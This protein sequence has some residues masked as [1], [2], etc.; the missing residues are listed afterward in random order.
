MSY[1]KL[2]EILVSYSFDNPNPE[3]ITEIKNNPF[4]SS[5]IFNAIV[6]C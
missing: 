3:S 5:S 4:Y 2:S 6:P 1:S